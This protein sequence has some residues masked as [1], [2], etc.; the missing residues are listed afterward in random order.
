MAIVL[1]RIWWIRGFTG[2]KELVLIPSS[3]SW[4]VTTHSKTLIKSIV[5]YILVCTM[6]MIPVQFN[7]VNL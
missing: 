7:P 6:A 3:M 2:F 1:I 5:S 4:Y